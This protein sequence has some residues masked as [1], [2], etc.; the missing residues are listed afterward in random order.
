MAKKPLIESDSESMAERAFA[1]LRDRIATLDFPPGALL[2]ENALSDMLDISRTPIREALKRL[3]SDK[4]VRIMPRRGIVVTPI[5]VQDQL[6]VL[7]VRRGLEGPLFARASQRSSKDQRAEFHRLAERLQ[8]HAAHKD[9]HAHYQDDMLFDRLIDECA[10]N[11][12]MS[13][14][15]RPV[16]TL[17]RRFWQLHRNTE[18]AKEVLSLH[19]KVAFSV[20]SGDPKAVLRDANV[21]FDFNEAFCR[22]L[23]G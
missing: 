4:L 20:A 17:V 2:S 5:D 9:L 14:I 15:L 1:F 3:E 19:V 10:Q 7:E 16:H 22:S 18:E 11:H 12:F 8:F 6:L 13:D 23:V 21:M